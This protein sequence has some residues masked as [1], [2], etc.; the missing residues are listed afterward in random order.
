MSDDR[1]PGRASGSL[2]PIILC[3]AV[4]CLGVVLPDEAL[5][6]SHHAC[7]VRASGRKSGIL[8]LRVIALVGHS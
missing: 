7:D 6:G 1:A 8:S 5:L 2:M 3:L 4:V